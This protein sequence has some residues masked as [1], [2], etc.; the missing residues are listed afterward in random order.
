MKNSYNYFKYRIRLE[1]LKT[2]NWT[3]CIAARVLCLIAALLSY[4]LR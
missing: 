4:Y 2:K 3:L 1:K